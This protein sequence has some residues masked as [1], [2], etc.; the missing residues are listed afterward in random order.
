MDGEDMHR[1]VGEARRLRPP[2]AALEALRRNTGPLPLATAQ[3]CVELA[4][5]PE[6]R[7]EPLRRPPAEPRPARM[8]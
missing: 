4:R 6:R 8:R 1:M 2:R 3:T 7:L 5:D